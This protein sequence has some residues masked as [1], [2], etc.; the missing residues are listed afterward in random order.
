MG[1]TSDVD[2]TK[3]HKKGTL[4]ENDYQS[5]VIDENG[6]YGALRKISGM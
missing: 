2:S 1:R 6:S 5:C 3:L 4:Y